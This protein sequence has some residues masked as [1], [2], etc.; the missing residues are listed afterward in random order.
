MG[1]MDSIAARATQHK[2]ENKQDEGRQEEEEGEEAGQEGQRGAEAETL[3]EQ[4][5]GEA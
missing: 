4:G 5:P 3:G 1:V 2:E